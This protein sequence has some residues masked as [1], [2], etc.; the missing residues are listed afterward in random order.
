MRLQIMSERLVKKLGAYLERGRAQLQPPEEETA[1]FLGRT[2]M[3]LSTQAVK[4]R[5]R[6]LGERAGLSQIVHPRL[7]A[8]SGQ[9]HRKE[10]SFE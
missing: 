8:R 9:V 3:R 6:A 2:G 5:L 10:Q 4:A 1:V 7:L